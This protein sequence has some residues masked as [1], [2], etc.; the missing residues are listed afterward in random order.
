M[1]ELVQERPFDGT[2][3]TI[4]FKSGTGEPVNK[5]ISLLQVIDVS[6]TAARPVEVFHCGRAVPA[7]DPACRQ[8]PR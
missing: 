4:V 6:D 1:R 3:G 7:D 2:A 8:P 5:R